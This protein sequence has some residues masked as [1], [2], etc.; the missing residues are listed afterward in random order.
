MVSGPVTVTATADDDQGLVGVQFKLNGENLGAEDRTTPY[1]VPWDTRGE[2][3][4]THVLSAVARDGAGNTTTSA[5]APVDVSNA[6]VSTVGLRLAYG[7]DEGS[8]DFAADSSGNNAT[9]TISGATWV[10]GRHGSAVSLDGSTGKVDVQPL[11]TFYRT[12][13]TYEAW[14]FKQGTKVDTAVV[15]TWAASQSG[16][17][18]IWIDHGNGRYHL[19]LGNSIGNYLDTGR[20]PAVGRWQHVAATYDGTTA[21]FYMDGDEVASKVFTGNVGSSNAWRIGAYGS[22]PNGF[23]DGS[24]DDVRIYDRALSASEIAA[25]MA[26]RIQP[27]VAPPTVTSSTPPDDATEVSVG[28]PLTLKF[29]E[30]MKPSTMT[31]GAFELRDSEGGLV[32]VTVSYDVP[33]STATLHLQAALEF[34]TQYTATV[35]AGGAADLAGNAFPV[36]DIRSFTTQASPPQVLVVHSPANPFGMYMTEILRG[37]GL[38][39][40]NT[41]DVALI[42]P[43]L[44]SHFDV[45]VLGET[46][47]DAGKV[48]VLSELGERRRQPD[49]DAAGR[50]ARRPA[51]ADRGRDDA[52]QRLPQGRHD[53][54]P[55]RGHRGRHDPVP[56]HR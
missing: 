42:T 7:F 52:R 19:T 36:D 31:A 45:V 1:S 38:N 23:L 13:F 48:S 30:P 50:A 44:L 16:G 53:H 22:T 40:F 20:A 4:G 47:L 56:R 55:R 32:P 41:I 11:G 26:T 51:R 6:G 2:A 14:V 27:D 10:S 3:N 18:M 33:S 43:A 34:A 35:E 15:G 29:S 28:D 24:V 54:G 49:R 8:G 37:E 39:E 9:G 25:G 12:A 5:P 21:R 17:A 46:T